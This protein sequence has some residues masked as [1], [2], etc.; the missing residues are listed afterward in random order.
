MQQQR[1]AITLKSAKDKYHTLSLL[2]GVGKE[3]TEGFVYVAEADSQT[4]EQRLSK[5]KCD[6]GEA[7][8]LVLI[9]AH[10]GTDD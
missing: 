4:P 8:S 2:C 9:Y 7:E 6:G 3:Y 10:G 1:W 5:G